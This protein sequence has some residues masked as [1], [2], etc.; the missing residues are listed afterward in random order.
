MGLRLFN[1]W[2]SEAVRHI[3]PDAEISVCS[4]LRGG[5]PDRDEA[6]RHAA[7]LGR[8]RATIH[9]TRTWALEASQP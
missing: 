9:S 8:M 2:T 7:Q 4:R 3:D 1:N 6:D 5:D